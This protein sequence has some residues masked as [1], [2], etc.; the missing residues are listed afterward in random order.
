M[1]L[2][3]RKQAADELESWL[4]D[5]VDG[6]PTA[7]RFRERLRT[8]GATAEGSCSVC[9]DAATGTHRFGHADHVHDTRTA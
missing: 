7:R 4:H 3:K 1:K 8:E 2:R 6:E 9:E 5:L